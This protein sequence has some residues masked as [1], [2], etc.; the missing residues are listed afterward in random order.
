MAGNQ[1]L[2][3]RF[4]ANLWIERGKVSED[5]LVSVDWTSCTGMGDQARRCS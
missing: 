4:C 5:G 2:L 3:D 1:A